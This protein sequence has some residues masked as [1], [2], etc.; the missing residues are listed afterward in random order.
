MPD[1]DKAFR[2]AIDAGG[3]EKMP[4]SDMFWGDRYGQF[5]DPYGYIWGISTRVHD[6]TEQEIAEGQKKFFAQMQQA[7]RKTA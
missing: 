1:V 4:V 7:Q 2:R 5:V 3:K 6:M